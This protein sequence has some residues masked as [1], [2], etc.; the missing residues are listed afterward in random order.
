ME[1]RVEQGFG[2]FIELLVLLDLWRVEKVEKTIV[3]D[4]LFNSANYKAVRLLSVLR[5]L[6]GASA[7]VFLLLFDDFLGNIHI[8]FPLD[9]AATAADDLGSLV[10]ERVLLVQLIR[11][12]IGFRQ[13]LIFKVIIWP[14]FEL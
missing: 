8:L 11:Q 7:L 1:V 2:V 3:Q 5:N 14:E 6:T 9:G 10:A 4:F 12:V 13:D